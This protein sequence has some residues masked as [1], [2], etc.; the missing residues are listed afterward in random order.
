M[1]GDRVYATVKSDEVFVFRYNYSE[2]KWE[3]FT[4]SANASAITFRKRGFNFFIRIVAG[5]LREELEEHQLSATAH[6][7]DSGKGFIQI[8]LPETKQLMGI[9]FKRAEMADI[10]LGKIRKEMNKT[11][12][13][14]RG[15]PLSVV[16]DSRARFA[17]R[18]LLIMSS[19][20]QLFSPLSLSLPPLEQAPV[21]RVGFL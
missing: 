3:N 6:V 11:L 5:G 18:K 2:K 16:L 9:K 15:A 17:I 10:F 7:V 13:P 20:Y 12:L 21:G 14:L 19:P 1:S 8:P 4:N